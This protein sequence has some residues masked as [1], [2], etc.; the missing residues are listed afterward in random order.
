MSE[1]LKYGLPIFLEDKTGLLTG[2][3]FTDL[4]NRCNISYRFFPY[5][6]DSTIRRYEV[7]GPSGQCR[8]S[9]IL[10]FGA[11]NSLGTIKLHSDSDPVPMDDYLP[12]VSISA[13]CNFFLTNLMI[14]C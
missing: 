11:D 13:R 1:D 12:K 8:K 14:A 10:T 7:N 3:N 6:S 9:I 2:S 4:Y 5:A